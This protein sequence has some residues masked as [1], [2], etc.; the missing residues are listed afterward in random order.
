[1]DLNE[2]VILIIVILSISLNVLLL[3][4]LLK[5]R[6]IKQTKNIILINLS[7]SSL[8]QGVI[9]YPIELYTIVIDE[10]IE[11]LHCISSAVLVFGLSLVAI[12]SLTLLSIERLLSVKYPF[13]KER[14]LIH[15]KKWF[16]LA[17]IFTWVISAFWSLIPLLGWSSY[18][19]EL[20]TAHR[21]NIDLKS[22]SINNTSYTYMLL[23]TCYVTPVA[24]MV[25]CFYQV[26]NEFKEMLQKARR[27]SGLKSRLSIA[28]DKTEKTQTKLV[29]LMIIAFLLAWTPYAIIV[30][31]LQFFK[32]LP[33]LLYNISALLAKTSTFY[34]A[35]IYG[36][37]YKDIRKSARSLFCIK[38]NKA[39][40]VLQLKKLNNNSLHY[41]SNQER[42][43]GQDLSFA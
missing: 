28:I 40:V 9:A 25:Y 17:V 20:Q 3:V 41:V 29:F 23:F 14:L 12:W 18:T 27:T 34:N 21:C 16:Y 35:L 15:N 30:F 4:T 2:T 43:L 32:H 1:M 13:L 8:L 33:N 24:I 7:I 19:L 31:I 36:F 5:Q 38:K 10:S 6:K 39:N 26:K 37:V 42:L 11:S 22:N